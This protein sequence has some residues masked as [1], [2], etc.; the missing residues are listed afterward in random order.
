[1]RR[2]KR[3]WRKPRGIDSKQRQKLKWAGA[4]VKVGYRSPVRERGVHP[5][6]KKE[7]LVQNAKDLEAKGIENFV[8]RLSGR[9][10]ARNKEA[11]RKKAAEKKFVVLN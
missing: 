7:F 4:V 11:I 1:M 6:G 8:L 9:L 3:V 2:V 10:S 5:K